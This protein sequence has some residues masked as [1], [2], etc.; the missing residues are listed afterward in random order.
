MAVEGGPELSRLLVEPA[1]L[2]RVEGLDLLLVGAAGRRGGSRLSGRGTGEGGGRR[3]EGK[4]CKGGDVYMCHY[5]HVHV[6][7]SH[8]RS[9]FM[10]I[11]KIITC[12]QRK[13]C[14]L[15]F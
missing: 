15:L 12:I 14:L 11:H 13:D 10:Y 6:Q 2:V 1:D 7:S 4:K 8:A 5:I 9:T 3:E